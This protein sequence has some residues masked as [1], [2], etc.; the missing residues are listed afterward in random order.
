MHGEL[1]Q[2]KHEKARSLLV[3]EGVIPPPSPT[4]LEGLSNILAVPLK[5]N[6]LVMKHAFQILLFEVFL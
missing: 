5:I 3:L 4:M 6:V 2:E 1:F